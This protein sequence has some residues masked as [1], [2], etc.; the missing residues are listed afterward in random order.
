MSKECPVLLRYFV[1][2]KNEQWERDIC[3]RCKEVQCILDYRK[4]PKMVI[5]RLLKVRIH[6]PK[7]NAWDKWEVFEDDGIHCIHCG[8]IIPRMKS[9]IKAK[10]RSL[11]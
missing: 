7:C 3:L 2:E 9:L 8:K 10:R 5:N 6:C 4:A 11:K 1:D